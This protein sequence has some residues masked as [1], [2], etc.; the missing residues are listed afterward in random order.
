M[1]ERIRQHLVEIQAAP[2][3]VAQA[4]APRIQAQLRADSTTRRGNVPSFGKFGDVPS[5]AV[6]VGDN[7]EVTCADWVMRQVDKRSQISSWVGIVLDETAAEF[8]RGGQ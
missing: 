8:R 3:R 5:V 1:F 4:S 7:I 2:A 6:A